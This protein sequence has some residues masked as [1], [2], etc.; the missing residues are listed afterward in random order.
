M[1]NTSTFDDLLV[2]YV[3]D[4]LKEKEKR[5]IEKRISNETDVLDSFVELDSMASEL[6]KTKPRMS[7]TSIESILD[8]SKSMSSIKKRS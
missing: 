3:Y 7:N 5:A 8:Y 6:N 4:E 2:L 1:I